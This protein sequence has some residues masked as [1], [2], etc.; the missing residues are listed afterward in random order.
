[1]FGDPADDECDGVGLLWRMH[2]FAIPAALPQRRTIVHLVLTGPGATEGWFSIDGRSIT[3][4]VD[5]P[6]RDV[7]LAVEGSTA[8][9]Q[10]WLVG[11]ADF[12]QLVIDGHVRLIGPARLARAFPGWFD[13]SRWA[14]D[15]RRA[16]EREVRTA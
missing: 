1:M 14:D 16:R 10:R 6:G 11:R 9:L 8:Q 15:A 7:D 12:R 13:T 4:C 5:D 3:V 2:Q